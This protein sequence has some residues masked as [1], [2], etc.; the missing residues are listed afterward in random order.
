M[1]SSPISSQTAVHLTEDITAMATKIAQSKFPSAV[2]SHSNE[3]N[4]KISL[5]GVELRAQSVS[6]PDT[7]S[8]SSKYR[9]SGKIGAGKIL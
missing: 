2:T 6:I 1:S 8:A 3:I 7:S 4:P 9:K 5:S